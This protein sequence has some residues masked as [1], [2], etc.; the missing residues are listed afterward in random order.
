MFC[1]SVFHEN[2]QVRVFPYE[3]QGT[4]WQRAKTL[5]IELAVKAEKNGYSY[6]VEHF[7]ASGVGAT[8]WK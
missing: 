8:V 2:K 1:Y 5:A 6:T 7:G 3:T 4:D